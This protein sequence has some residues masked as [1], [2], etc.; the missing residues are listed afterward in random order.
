MGVVTIPG[1]EEFLPYTG[2]INYI[3]AMNELFLAN[4]SID[5][6]IIPYNSD[7]DYLYYLLNRVNGVFFTGGSLDLYDEST[8][9]LHSYSLTAKKILN[10]AMR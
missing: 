7:D 3:F 2:K 4:A 1:K 5:S 10:Y 8:G 9:E 6:V